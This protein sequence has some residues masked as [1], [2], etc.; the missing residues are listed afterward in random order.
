MR[1]AFSTRARYR[2]DTKA[3]QRNLVSKNQTLIFL[4]TDLS[5]DNNSNGLEKNI[6]KQYSYNQKYFIS[7]TDE[8]ALISVKK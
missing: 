7:G 5:V 2:T 1:P 8:E 6:F 4:A 3:T